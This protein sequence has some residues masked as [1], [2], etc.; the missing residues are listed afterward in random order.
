MPSTIGRQ[1]CDICIPTLAN[2]FS[3]LILGVLKKSKGAILNKL[4]NA[5]EFEVLYSVPKL[6]LV[7]HFAT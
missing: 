2:S 7:L 4:K 1:Q 3:F 5:T 6:L